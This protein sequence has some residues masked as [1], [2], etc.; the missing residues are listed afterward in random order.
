VALRSSKASAVALAGLK[1]TDGTVQVGAASVCTMLTDAQATKQAIAAWPTL[2]T[3][4]QV[5][6]LAGW[7]DRPEPAAAPLAQQAI[8]SPDATLRTTG[9]RAAAKIE[10]ARAVPTLAKL[11]AQ[12]ADPDRRTARESLVSLPGKEAEK[13]ILSAARQGEPPMRLALTGVIADRGTPGALALLLEE[14]NGSDEKLAAEAV[15]ALGTAA[16]P[17]DYVA[18][19]RVLTTT[20][21]DLVRDAAQG[22]V[23]ASAQHLGD[24]DRAAEPVLAAMPGASAPVRAALI[25]TL[26]EIGGDRALAEITKATS[27][28]DPEVKGAAVHALADTWADSRPLPTLLALAKSDPNKTYRVQA[29]RG[30]L[31]L[32]G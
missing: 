20:K 17:G 9:I 11:A 23:V 31:R 8:D 22:A 15:K 10:G 2:P 19:V 12:G 32:V 29:L 1:A 6:L 24:P 3:P 7:A 5:V 30:Y 14:A 18:L 16:G 13:A 28:T 4:V 27:A 21:S 26:A 25:A